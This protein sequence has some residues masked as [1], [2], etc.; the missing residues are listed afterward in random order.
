[1]GRLIW[2]RRYSFQSV[3]SLKAGAHVE[4]LHGHQYFLE[5][6]FDGRDI[7][8]V[9]AVVEREVLKPLHAREVEDIRP[10]TG[11]CIVDWIDNRLR[12]SNIGARIIAVALQ[13]TRKNRF[14][15]AHTE[16]KY[17]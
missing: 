11:E 16:S 9:D 13:E 14:V 1:M 10:S 15:S 7:D 17:V 5:V 6:S 8:A 2:T 4:S 12:Q 3:H